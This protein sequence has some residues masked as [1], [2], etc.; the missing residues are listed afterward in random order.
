MSTPSAA[1]ANQLTIDQQRLAEDHLPLVRAIAGGWRKSCR[2]TVD[3]ADLVQVGSLGLVEAARRFDPER[4][5]PFAALAAS[6]IRGA[7]CDFFRSLDPLT[8][9]RRA[10]VRTLES[11]SRTL[12]DRLGRAPQAEELEAKLGWKSDAVRSASADAAALAAGWAQVCDASV[13]TSDDASTGQPSVEQDSLSVLL[14]EERAQQL[15]KALE[16]LTERERMVLDL[17]YREEL[18][19][20]EVGKVLGVTES[21]VSQVRTAATRRLRALLEA[22]MQMAA[23]A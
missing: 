4:G 19:L 11:S 18:T 10:A 23:A 20:K 22:P 16:G 13:L 21:R 3:Y 15:R 9:D 14:Q 17:C 5:V 2:S 8:R 1:V 7:I 12:A 6:R